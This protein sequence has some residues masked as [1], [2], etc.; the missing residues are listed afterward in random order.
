MGWSSSEELSSVLCEE[1]EGEELS[2]D[3]EDDLC[4]RRGVAEEDVEEAKSNMLFLFFF[5]PFSP[6]PLALPDSM[7]DGPLVRALEFDEGE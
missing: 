2:L 1:E 7:S 3:A 6:I 4:R 5:L